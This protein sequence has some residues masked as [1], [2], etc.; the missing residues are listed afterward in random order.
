MLSLIKETASGAVDSAAMDTMASK[1]HVEHE[2]LRLA[3]QSNSIHYS[4]T[5]L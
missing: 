2:T 1:A 3:Y 4:A 5:H